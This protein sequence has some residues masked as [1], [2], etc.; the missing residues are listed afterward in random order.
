MGSRI[1]PPTPHEGGW[2]LHARITP[3]QPVPLDPRRCLY[4]PSL[5][6]PPSLHAEGSSGSFIELLPGAAEMRFVS[7]STLA[8]IVLARVARKELWI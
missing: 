3:A 7:G 1:E 2:R 4:P 8:M 5:V 6:G